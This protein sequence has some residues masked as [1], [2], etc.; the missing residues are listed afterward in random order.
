L[1]DLGINE[2]TGKEREIEMVMRKKQDTRCDMSS[3][4]QDPVNMNIVYQ[5][6]RPRHVMLLALYG[7]IQT[8]RAEQQTMLYP[9]HLSVIHAS[10]RRRS[11]MKHFNAAR[12]LGF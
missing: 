11:W 3:N 6:K 5:C 12:M 8:S 9:T 1:K 10:I 2:K 4:Y 7:L